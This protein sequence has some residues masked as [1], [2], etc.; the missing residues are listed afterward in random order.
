MLR[1]AEIKLAE[2]PMA[3]LDEDGMRRVSAALSYCLGLD[4]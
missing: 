4:G 2:G 3:E 1:A